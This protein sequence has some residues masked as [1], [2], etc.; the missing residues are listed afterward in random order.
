M[1][2]IIT[3]LETQKRNTDR[4][5]V[6]LD[7]DFVFGVSRFVGAWLSVGQKI[8]DAKMQVLLNS[9]VKEKAYQAA[10]RYISY[11]QRTENEIIK[12]LVKLDFPSGIINDVVGDLKEKGYVDDKE[13][14]N[15]WI[16]LRSESKPSSKRFLQ[17]ELQRKGISE[18]KINSALEAAPDD[19]KQAVKLGRKN[20]KRYSRIDDDEFRKKIVGVLSRRAFSYSVIKEALFEL[21]RLRNEEKEI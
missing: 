3:A 10:L 12:K 14:A 6:F 17:Y 16:Q 19:L 8:D 11:R 5:N 9:D 18:D 15:Q 13:F 7:G 1:E 21:L 20:L 4:I 2:K